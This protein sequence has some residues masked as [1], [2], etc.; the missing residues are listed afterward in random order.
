MN[1]NE[2]D[3]QFRV[4]IQNTEGYTQ[5]QLDS[6]NDR[7]FDA[8]QDLDLDDVTT[9]STADFAMEQA[10]SAERFVLNRRHFS[11]WLAAHGKL[12]LIPSAVA[13]EAEDVIRARL[14]AGEDPGYELGSADTL[15]GNPITYYP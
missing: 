15:S 12:G 14:D 2:F 7:V 9:K 8:V 10:L 6:I 4:T 13:D 1:R 5:D 11:E 3:S